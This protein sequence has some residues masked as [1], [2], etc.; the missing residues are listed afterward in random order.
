MLRKSRRA[1]TLVAVMATAAG[2]MGLS[3]PAAAEPTFT[4]RI[5]FGDQAATPPAGYLSDY[6]QAFGTRSGPNQGSGLQYGWVGVGTATPLDMVGNGRNRGT[7]SEP[8][9]RLATLMHMQLPAGSPG[10]QAPG[11]WEIA[12]PNGVYTV[13]VAVGD[14]QHF[15]S[16]HAIQ[17]EDQNAITAFT[18]STAVRYSTATVNVGVY[19]G[20]LT[21]S[22]AQ[23]TNTKLSYVTIAPLVGADDRPQ[24]RAVTPAN[25]AVEMP[26]TGSVVADLRLVA[27]GVDPSTLSTSTVTLTNTATGAAVPAH[28]ITSGGAD[29]VNLSPTTAL[30]PDT[31][32]R[33]T[34]TSG[35]KDTAGRSFVGWQSVFTTGTAPA[36][37]GVAFDKADSGASGRKFASMVKGPDGKLYA[38]TLD[39]YIERYTIASDGTLTGRQTIS[40]IRDNAVAQG[41]PGAPN[42]TVLGLAFDPA[43]TA[44]NLILWITSNTMYAGE[45]P[46]NQPDWTSKIAKLSGPNLATYTEVVTNLPR[47]VLDHQ[48]N[49]LAFG[50]DGAL[51]VP[52]GGSNAMGAP[53]SAW[54]DRPEHLLTAAVLRL[55]PAKL[56]ATLPLD[57][58]T[59][60]PGTYSPFATNAP[61]TLHAT[62]VRN[63]F[64]LVW[65][66]N[67]HLYVPTNG[68]GAGGNTPAT[69]SPLPAVC[70]N[71]IDKA[72][73]GAYTGPSVPAITNNN[74]AETDYVFDVKKGRYYGHP[75]PTRCEWTLG[76]GNPTL[77]VDPFEQTTY[78]VGTL[79]DR[80]IDLAGMYEAGM[81]AS[82]NGVIEYKSNS[83]GGRLKGKLLVV[84]YSN[85]QDIETFD[86]AASGVLSNRSSGIT[87]FTGFQQPL[88]L[89]EDTATGNIYV[90]ELGASKITL[91]RPRVM[92]AGVLTVRNPQGGP[93]ND[94]FVFNRI[95][96]PADSAQKTRETS[97][98]RLSNTGT[99]ALKILGLPVTGQFKLDPA[100]TLPLT[101]QPGGTV[102]LTVRFT[103]TAT[104]LHTGSLTVSSN[105]STK[106]STVIELAGYWQSCSECDEPIVRDIAALMGFTTNIPAYLDQLG[107]VAPQGDEIIA[108][109]WNRADATKPV[110][111][112]QINV[113]RGYPNSAPV[114]WY[115][116]GGSRT[117]IT[118][119][120]G[121]WAQ[122]VMPSLSTGAPVA[123]SF[124]PT[125][126]FG[127]AVDYVYSD[128]TK[129]N[130][131]TDHSRG[132]VDP[133][134]QGVRFFP[135]KDRQGSVIPNTY[136]MIMD[137]S[138]G[139]YDY[140]D[141]G[142][143]ITNITK[144]P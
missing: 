30:A 61:L 123:G 63:A 38:S 57:A 9:Q 124:N 98:V 40:T 99:E 119:V 101:I 70:A 132:C 142:Y 13:T 72:T 127:F 32:Y 116:K 117:T 6:G 122:S 42:R 90:S 75:N 69:P 20:R 36:P 24:V 97:V 82:A 45:I 104:H 60:A 118:Q 79:P 18:P 100:P 11:S 67:G 87:G 121:V 62:G 143:I 26:T 37:E 4:A 84:R 130:Q 137:F 31:R 115:P 112:T 136:Y 80:N 81:H 107:H 25:T 28:V 22:P 19:D 134:G 86:V 83:F 120:A 135:I 56:P 41:L 73:A 14:P 74:Q 78:P 7:G 59:E 76:G 138:G 126:T 12:V 10:V 5:D 133:C 92:S 8:D 43:S 17:V 58:R 131:A 102:D 53:D 46:F 96:T 66:T 105:S 49:S 94:R 139:N 16:V 44:A 129:N 29:V 34:I 93:F 68:S 27:G 64:D 15:N 88:D 35:V 71:R 48:T 128:P 95:N 141:N 89:I 21:I 1:I 106:H 52:Q 65:H 114:S 91:V 55:D 113:F 103:A 23:G 109:Y 51:Y 110:M 111:V 85:G 108:P 33:F 47:S 125:G 54:G 50:P 77:A 2:A 39:G 144:A 140:N 3:L